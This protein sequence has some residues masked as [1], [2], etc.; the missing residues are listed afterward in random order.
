MWSL[1][2][3]PHNSLK[4]GE[5]FRTLYDKTKDLDNTR[6]VTVV[7]MM[8]VKEKAFEFVDVLCINRYYG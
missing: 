5:F 3:E 1:A 8:G 7:N 4:S 6:P 2:N